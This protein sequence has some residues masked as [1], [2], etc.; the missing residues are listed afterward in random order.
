MADFEAELN[1]RGVFVNKGSA[2]FNHFALFESKPKAR[3]MADMAMGSIDGST[4][5]SERFGLTANQAGF[6]LGDFSIEETVLSDA[7]PK[8]CFLSLLSIIFEDF[9]ESNERCYGI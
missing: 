2:A 9:D 6:G 3:Q 7:C 8:V 4:Y 1:R 5:L